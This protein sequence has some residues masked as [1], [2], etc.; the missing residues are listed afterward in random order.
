MHGEVDNDARSVK[1]GTC[2][3]S[4]RCVVWSSNLEFSIDN[5]DIKVYLI[6]SLA[7]QCSTARTADSGFRSSQHRSK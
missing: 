7:S 3:V 5:I 6:F 2:D 4:V 1:A